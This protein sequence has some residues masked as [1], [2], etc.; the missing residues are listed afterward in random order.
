MSWSSFQI[1]TE[2]KKRLEKIRDG[3]DLSSFSEAIDFLIDF[4]EKGDVKT[5]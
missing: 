2:T 3:K 5:R 4:H 1:R